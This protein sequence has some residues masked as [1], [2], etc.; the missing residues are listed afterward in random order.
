M[1]QVDDKHLEVFITLLNKSCPDKI[2]YSALDFAPNMLAPSDP[3]IH[4]LVFSLFLW[5]ASLSHA[6]KAMDAIRTNLA[7]Y[8]ELRVCFP[9]E[10]AAIIGT[11][12]PNAHE[13]CERIA[14]ALNAVFQRE[15]SL[16]LIHL[17]DAPKRDARQYLSTLDGVPDFVAARVTL[18]A[19]GG[20]AFPLDGLLMKYLAQQGVL[21]G[22]G[23]ATQHMGK[24]ERA[25]RATESRRIYGMIE[26]WADRKRNT[27]STIDE[28]DRDTKANAASDEDCS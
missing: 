19:L 3:V 10:L 22:A 25:V 21:L 17:L 2:R 24:L 4:E 11:R 15:Q 8:N 12:Y 23:T 16:K 18:I 1:S 26:Y 6:I 13:R 20:H 9:D 27:C 7:D 28:L 14:A 5:E